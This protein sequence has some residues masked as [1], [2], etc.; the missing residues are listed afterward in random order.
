MIKGI[1]SFEVVLEGLYLVSDVFGCTEGNLLVDVFIL[2]DYF[3]K[4]VDVLLMEGFFFN[5]I[6]FIGIF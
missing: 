6:V 1:E 3:I 5:C 2:V 4:F